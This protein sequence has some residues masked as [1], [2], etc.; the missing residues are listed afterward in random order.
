[1]TSI[2]RLIIATLLLVP[3]F[4][5]RFTSS[6]HAQSAG[7]WVG[8]ECSLYQSLVGDDN[9]VALPRETLKDWQSAIKCLVQLIALRKPIITG[10]R[11]VLAQKDVLRAAKALRVILDENGQP[12]I[13][14]FRQN[15]NLD[16]I[17]VLAYA[18]RSS[19]REFR[20]N[21]TL[22]LGNVVDNASICVPLDHLY[23]PDLDANGRTNLLAVAVGVATYAV[24]ENIANIER[25][26][27]DV[28][29]NLSGDLP[30]TRRIIQNAKDRLQTRKNASAAD[31]N[32]R[33]K[34]ELLKACRGYAPIWAKDKFRY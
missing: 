32:P 4:A 15:D 30:D 21:A 33:N 7:A 25:A 11:D 29:S 13:T 20:V 17:S 1:M 26:V 24:D 23:A 12:S 2:R 22:V 3:L 16:A 18:A 6:T 31:R 34:D 8:K 5:D 14:F 9:I 10:P 27:Q 19:D 28:E